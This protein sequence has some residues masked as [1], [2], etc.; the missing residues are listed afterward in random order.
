MEFKIKWERKKIN[1]RLLGITWLLLNYTIL[2]SQST[3]IE[4]SIKRFGHEEGVNLSSY[5][6]ILRDSSDYLWIFG[7][8]KHP[9]TGKIDLEVISYDGERFTPHAIPKKESF[10]NQPFYQAF[11]WS[12]GEILLQ[13]Y[14]PNQL[15]TFDPYTGALENI[16]ANQNEIVAFSLGIGNKNKL[17]GIGEN[18]KEENAVVIFEK[19]KISTLFYARFLKDVFGIYPDEDGIWICKLTEVIFCDYSGKIIYRENIGNDNLDLYVHANTSRGIEIFIPEKDPIIIDKQSGSIKEFPLKALFGQGEIHQIVVDEYGNVIYVF[20]DPYLLNHV[21]LV[22]KTG[23]VLD[24]SDIK[25]EL[26]DIVKIVGD[27][28]SKSFWIISSSDLVEVTIQNNYVSQYL[29]NA[30]LRKIKLLNDQLYVATE[31]GGIYRSDN[32]QELNFSFISSEHNP[33]LLEMTDDGY[34]LTNDLG[35]FI[36][37]KKDE[38]KVFDIGDA[39]F[40]AISL[41]DTLIVIGSRDGLYFANKEKWTA[42]PFNGPV[43]NFVHKLLRINDSEFLIASVDGL[44]KMDIV[45]YKISLLDTT[46]SV[47]SIIEDQPGEWYYGTIN[48][49]LNK[50]YIDDVGFETEH[51]IEV[52]ATIA[53]ITKDDLQ[54]LWIGTFNGI[55]VYDLPS[56]QL[57]RIDDQLVSHTECN[58]LSSF[59]DEKHR[60]MMIGTVHGLNVFNVD[61]VEFNTS[62]QRLSLTYLHYFNKESNDNDTILLYRTDYYKLKIDAYHRY[63]EVGFGPGISS[64]KEIEYFYALIP[65]LN[66]KDE[67]FTWI[68]NGRNAQ[69]SLSNLKSGSY[70]LLIKSRD[71]NTGL[72]S[73][74]LTIAL[75]V[76]TFFYNQWWFYLLIFIMIS[77]LFYFWREHLKKENIRLEQEVENR[78][79]ELRKDKEIIQKQ[80][81][82]LSILDQA[83]T[84]FYNNISHELK[85]PLTLISGPLESIKEGGYIKEERANQLVNLIQKN[86]NH[87][88]GRVEEL[89][90]INRLENKKVGINNTPILLSDFVKDHIEIF[91][92]LADDKNIEIVVKNGNPK[93]IILVDEKKLGKVVQNLISN[94]LKYCPKGSRIEIDIFLTGN[95]LHVSVDDNG[96]G[97]ALEY[98]HL[99]FDKFYQLPTNG[100]SM[101]GSGIG[102]S[103]VKEYVDLMGGNIDLRSEVDSGTRFEIII[104]IKIKAKEIYASDQEEK[105]PVIEI[106]EQK[107]KHILVVE[108]N[109]DLRS[110]LMLMLS[111]YF[112]ISAANNGI[113]ALTL[114]EKEPNIELILSDIMMPDMDGMQ[115]LEKV[116]SNQNWQKLPFIFLTAKQNEVSRFSALRLGV[117]DYLTKP[118]SKNELLLRM[119]RLLKNLEIRKLSVQEE[120]I[121]EEV[122]EAELYKKLEKFVLDSLSDPTFNVETI[123]AELGMSNRSLRRYLQKEIG[124]TPNEFIVEVKMNLL[125]EIRNGDKEI[126]LK[127]LAEKVGYLDHKYMSRL[128][129]ERFGYRL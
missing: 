12:N 31:S 30:E 86:V 70:K 60:Q 75:V 7:S 116:K 36:K 44:T 125:R 11:P 32:T 113:E 39:A 110:F 53:T 120:E 4:I 54:R 112:I 123:A 126:T 50:L 42:K 59:F 68:N 92:E 84:T 124:M 103:I 80:A 117:D 83:K 10:E 74:N 13:T 14:A 122:Q 35:L 90:E 33:R 41:N 16:L 105:A 127:E 99:I 102:L 38:L 58:R 128:F 82:E 47:L 93:D 55:F 107:T 100:H 121:E 73:N 79:N 37:R 77:V 45:D 129:F 104:P 9:I 119:M 48:G 25:L 63:L 18:Q 23:N 28:F 3:P 49:Q 51:I 21:Y 15:F 97:I 17:F 64:T 46:E 81:E 26:T 24:L 114:L 111:D 34:L 85:T 29:I 118:F 5:H 67:D 71:I 20:T 91:F 22:D 87:L 52:G 106:P 115:L 98:Q 57:F 95:N 108:D 65:R 61:K 62:K 89:L 1:T 56:K 94:A 101:S 76:G 27:N 72:E 78:T 96:N 6:S 2:W 88:T 19:N 43:F 69:V 40:D 66:F 109:E 8:E